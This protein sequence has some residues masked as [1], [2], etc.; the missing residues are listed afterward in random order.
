MFVVRMSTGAEE[1]AGV[2]FQIEVV[3]ELGVDEVDVAFDAVG[4]EEIRGTPIASNDLVSFVGFTCRALKPPGPGPFT[5]LPMPSVRPP[6]AVLPVR[7]VES[8]SSGDLDDLS[9]RTGHT[10][11]CPVM[12]FHATRRTSFHTFCSSVSAV[13]FHERRKAAKRQ[14]AMDSLLSSS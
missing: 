12:C 14:A 13:M 5:V 9:F 6:K 10:P 3:T 2:N 7:Y 8:E 1:V 11:F 4:S